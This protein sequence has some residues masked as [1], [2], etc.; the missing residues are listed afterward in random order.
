MCPCSN[1]VKEKASLVKLGMKFGR[2]PLDLGVGFVR[3]VEV[4]A[5]APFVVV[6][7]AI[8]LQHANALFNVLQS[9]LGWYRVRHGF[10]LA[11]RVTFLVDFDP[12]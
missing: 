9:K 12:F 3:V 5:V 10:R 4:V 8:A 2:P 11:T 1:N 6:V 7:V